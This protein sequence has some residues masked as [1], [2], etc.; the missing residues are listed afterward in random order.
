MSEI[1][2]NSKLEEISNRTV[3]W[4]ASFNPR[5]SK[6]PKKNYSVGN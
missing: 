3:Q 6:K 4:K 2:L 1:A 5:Q